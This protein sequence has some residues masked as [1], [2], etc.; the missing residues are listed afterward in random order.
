[1]IAPW[2]KHPELLAVLVKY[3]TASPPPHLIDRSWLGS[4]VAEI[5][6]RGD[7]GCSPRFFQ[8]KKM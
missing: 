5:E 4:Q 6:Y 1:M 2:Y 3:L 7:K 8:N